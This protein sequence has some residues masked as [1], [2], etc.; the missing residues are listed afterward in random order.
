MKSFEILVSCMGEDTINLV[1]RSNIR[2][3][4]VV[5]D[6]C[7]VNIEETIDYE[8]GSIKRVCSTERGLSNSRNMAIEKA[9]SD[10]CLISDDDEIFV[11]DLKENVLKA[12]GE[13]PE[14][15]IIVFRMSN[16]NSRIKNVTH[17]MKKHEL[18]RVSSWMISFKLKSIKNKICFDNKIG[19]GTGNGGGEEIKFLLDCYKA[20]L[21]IYY[22][23]FC[24]GEVNHNKSQW[25][26]GY[27]EKYFFQRGATTRYYMGFFWSFMY[28]LYFIMTK[29]N[30]Y[31]ANIS[32]IQ[33]TKC[34]IAGIRA[35][36]R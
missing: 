22:Y 18:L 29:R 35:S 9:D 26:E 33:A 3:N 27:N 8:F 10:Y 1:K 15:D 4:C 21:K 19:S 32:M 6:Q 25:F 13:I 34:L 7:D 28:G 36:I 12:Y 16:F 14:A 20:G 5:V 31:S 17:K 23:A 11:D 2:S 30:L 24:I